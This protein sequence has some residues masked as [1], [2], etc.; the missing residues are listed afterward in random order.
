MFGYDFSSLLASL[1]GLVMALSFHEYAHARAATWQGDITPQLMGRLT[2]N[3]LAH[4]D[5]IGMLMLLLV[6]FGWAKPVIINPLNFRD[7]RY[8]ELY[9]ALAGPAANLALAFLTMF[10]MQVYGHIFLKMSYGLHLVMSLVVMY[11]INFAIF[12]LIPIPPLD[13]S[14]VL[15]TFL[16]W[17]WQLKL[18]GLRRYGFII[19]VICLM[20]PLLSYILIPLSNVILTVF[21]AIL[22]LIF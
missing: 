15:R 17:E 18:D 5:P 4:I 20:T 22:R 13:G 2:I 19:M 14:T 1:P 7:R 21:T 8:G 16:P 6:R 11:N 9:V 3:P 12:N 10:A